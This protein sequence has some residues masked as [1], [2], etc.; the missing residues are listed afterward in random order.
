M[1]K[2]FDPSTGE[3]KV[4]ASNRGDGL[5]TKSIDF[6]S[7]AFDAS[8]YEDND[9]SIVTIDEALYQLKKEIRETKEGVAWVYKNGTVGG[10]GG[11]GSL[12]NIS[13]KVES[14]NYQISNK[15]IIV[16]N[17]DTIPLNFSIKG[18]AIGRKMIITIRDKEGN[19]YDGYRNTT[20]V[21]SSKSTTITIPNITKDTYIEF[22]GYDAETLGMI[23]PYTL[24]IRVAALKI[25]G[26]ESIQIP[27]SDTEYN[28]EY[29]IETTEGQMTTLSLSTNIEGIEYRYNHDG[30]FSYN[31][32]ISLN[33]FDIFSN[34][35]GKLNLYDA[36]QRGAVSN[37]SII[38][39]VVGG[40]F[41]AKSITSVVV[42][43]PNKITID[44][45]PLDN[46]S[47]LVMDND[48]EDHYIQIENLGADLVPSYQYIENNNITF[49]VK[50]YFNTQQY[51]MYYELYQFDS[52][53]TPITLF[54]KGNLDNYLDISNQP[55]GT[56]FYQ[57][58]TQVTIPYSS[59]DNIN[60]EKPI[61]I[62]VKAWDK[63]D[64][65]EFSGEVTKW[66]GIQNDA[67]WAPF[68]VAM[69][70]K[71]HYDN[72]MNYLYYY[73][74][75]Y[76]PMEIPGNSWLSERSYTGSSTSSQ[77]V[78]SYIEYYNCNN[79]TN[80]LVLRGSGLYDNNMLRLSSNAYAKILDNNKNDFIPF[81]SNS[82][83]NWMFDPNGWTMSFLVNTDVQPD[84]DNV[85]I[86]CANFD[87]NDN[88]TEGIYITTEDVNVIFQDTAGDN[89]KF[90]LTAKLAQGMLNQID[91]VFIPG[92]ASD[93]K[94]QLKLYVN[95]VLAAAGIS[96]AGYFE[97]NGIKS[98]TSIDMPITFGAKNSIMSGISKAADVNIYRVM[99]Y[100]R[101]LTDFHIVKNY[102]QGQAEVNLLLDG[103]IDK[104][105]NIELRNKNFF[106]ANDGKCALIDDRIENWA[107]ECKV[108]DNLYTKL[109]A[110]GNNPL[111]IVCITVEDTVG[112]QFRNNV[113]SRYSEDEVAADK[114][115]PENEK[116]I[117]KKYQA[118]F[119]IIP[120]KSTISTA[121]A[122]G[123][124]LNNSITKD[125]AQ[126][127]LPWITLQ[128]TSTLGYLS[129]NFQIGFGH[130]DTKG[131]HLVQAF[132]DMLPENEYILKADVM[133]SGHANNAAIGKF[134][135]EF[136][137]SDE[138]LIFPNTARNNNANLYRKEVKHTTLGH[139][140]IL[141][142][143]F[144]TTEEP[145]FMGIYSFNL[146]RISYYN[147]GYNVFDG[148]YKVISDSGEGATEYQVEYEN[149][150]VK[151]PDIKFPAYVSTYKAI[152]IP[153]TSDLEGIDPNYS[154]A[155]CYECNK[156]DNAVGSFQQYNVVESFYDKVYPDEN[157]TNT[158]KALDNFKKIF[159][160]TANMY[161]V[162]P[163]NDIASMTSESS[164]A[165]RTR[166]N[167]LRN[168]EGK[169]KIKGSNE[170][171]VFNLENYNAGLY[172][173]F[174]TKWNPTSQYLS[175]TSPQGSTVDEEFNVG[176][177]WDHASA[178]F[179]LAMLF[180][181]TDSLGKN[182]NIRSF[183]QKSWYTSFYDMDTGLAL[184]NSGNESVK[185][186]AYLD[187][188]GNNALGNN[189]TVNING[190]SSG[191][192][193][194]FNSRLWNIV[195]F[196]TNTYD[197][198]DGNKP[199]V[200]Y[201]KIWE[202][203]RKGMLLDPNNF[204]DNY[205]IAQNKNVGEIIFNQD[206][207]TKYVQDEIDKIDN[208]KASATS[209]I[210]LLHGNRV[211]FVKDWF[212]KHVY[213]LDGV[214][215]LGAKDTT[216]SQSSIQMYGNYAATSGT[217]GGD[218]SKAISV[219]Y[220]IDEAKAAPYTI[221]SDQ[222]DRV[223]PPS[224]GSR[225][226]KVKSNIPMFFIYA[227]ST[228]AQRMYIPEGK[229]TT[230]SLNLVGGNEQTM[231][232]N[233]VP[234]LTTF[235]K[236][237]NMFYV[238]M[239]DIK[240]RMLTKL[241]LSNM[242]TLSGKTFNIG[243]MEELRILNMENVTV[244]DQ[245]TYLT[246][247][248]SNAKKINY[249]NLRNA[250]VNNLVLPGAGINPGGSLETLII[251]KTNITSIDLTNQAMLST[252]SANGCQVLK[253]LK[254]N[255]NHLLKNI[256]NLPN[257]IETLTIEECKSLES[258]NLLN[259]KYLE[260]WNENTRKGFQ[261]GKVPNL[262]NFSY[263][264]SN[265]KGAKYL[266]KLD[267]SGATSLETLDIQGF[268]GEYITLAYSAKDTLKDINIANSKIRYI[269]WKDITTDKEYISY[270]G[271]TEDNSY[272]LFDYIDVFDFSDCK[273]LNSF[274]VGNTLVKYIILPTH[275]Y[276][277]VDNAILQC[278]NLERIIGKIEISNNTLLKQL[279]KF[280]FND[281]AR[282]YPDSPGTVGVDK[283]TNVILNYDDGSFSLAELTEN[284]FDV[285][286]VGNNKYLNVHNL[287]TNFEFNIATAEELCANSAINI[288]DMYSVLIKLGKND[289]I[290]ELVKTFE[291]CIHIKC[292][293]NNYISGASSSDKLNSYEIEKADLL[294]S[295]D[296]FVDNS[297]FSTIPHMFAKNSNIKSLIRTFAN[298]YIISDLDENLF[299]PLVNLENLTETF[300]GNGKYWVNDNMFM[301]NTN[302]KVLIN[303]FT[304]DTGS[305][306]FTLGRFFSK[307]SELEIINN[308]FYNTNVNINLSESSS[309]YRTLTTNTLGKIK[310]IQIFVNNPK[311]HTI[312]NWMNTAS[313][314]ITS[315]THIDLSD[316]FGGV[317]RW[318]Y[319]IGEITEDNLTFTYNG[320]SCNINDTYPR[321]LTNLSHALASSASSNESAVLNWKYMDKL[322]YNLK[323]DENYNSCLE[324]C[325][326][327]FKGIAYTDTNKIKTPYAMESNGEYSKFPIDIF[328]VK[329]KDGNQIY[330]NNLTNVS[331]MFE[332]AAFKD[333]LD[334]PGNIFK[335]CRNTKGLNISSFLKN[336]TIMP[337][338]LVSVVTNPEYDCFKNCRLTIVDSVLEGCGLG[339]SAKN[340]EES[341][342]NNNELF[343]RF[344]YGGVRNS[345]PYKFF[346]M[347]DNTGRVI[348]NI[349]SM[350]SAFAGCIWMGC[351]PNTSNYQY[352]T[353]R[354]KDPNAFYIT[355]RPSLDELNNIL[356]L[357]TIDAS[358]LGTLVDKDS[359]GVYEWDPWSYDGTLLSNE[360]TSKLTAD[361]LNKIT[362]NSGKTTSGKS[363]LEVKYE[364]LSDYEQHIID[365]NANVESTLNE[366]LANNNDLNNA[367][368]GKYEVVSEN[369]S[370]ILRIYYDADKDSKYVNWD[371]NSV[372]NEGN[373]Y[374][375]WGMGTDLVDLT[376]NHSDLLPTKFVRN[377]IVPMDIFRYCKPDCNIN[378]IFENMSRFNR[379]D[380][381]DANKRMF[382]YGM[383][384]RIPPRIFEPL[385]DLS[386]MTSVFRGCKGVVPYS[387]SLDGQFY[388]FMLKNNKNL[389]NISYTF[390][391]ITIL[392]NLSDDLI[393]YNSL[394]RNL[395]GMFENGYM[396]PRYVSSSDYVNFIPM[397]L[398]THSGTISNL[399]YMFAS[400]DNE[401]DESMMSFDIY[402]TM[403][404]PANNPAL[405]SVAGIFYNQRNM[406]KTSSNSKLFCNFHDFGNIDYMNAYFGTGYDLSDLDDDIKSKYGY[407]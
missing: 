337:I 78:K 283:L 228:N 258:I 400:R 44:V 326:Y 318:L 122:F 226:F 158:E 33:I 12:G 114:K 220:D 269:K 140:C 56:T 253:S 265:E 402:D 43:N 364:V 379:T 65:V 300:I 170:Y 175:F 193:D 164:N 388:R 342:R 405:V 203:L 280:K 177:V 385:K 377:Y 144:R 148:L 311:L 156:N 105:S 395:E 237:G 201:R 354:Y 319:N 190:Y 107:N 254:L 19:V 80:G 275:K 181:L 324:E 2:I 136:L 351:K 28:I 35:N 116:T 268:A 103:T 329:D 26:P 272:E 120:A 260:D 185:K 341:I 57:P 368:I 259:M 406:P 305:G 86:S 174:D 63:V 333:T 302:I 221:K 22:S 98:Y 75:S 49:T 138:Q 347:E 61:F 362:E 403:L 101:W 198:T 207:Y 163:E 20:Y 336:T 249:I 92:K 359:N 322:F 325:A 151:N 118:S 214:F 252:F 113:N 396:I 90:N 381:T 276:F 320:V 9:P 179:V 247:N 298:T 335:Y 382:I 10:G 355:S 230:I 340:A 41:E 372:A 130:S 34:E 251:D 72:Y 360:Y 227:N 266:T 74:N 171:E 404:I 301:Y 84:T 306:D 6:T 53:N 397:D 127:G 62:Y 66:F 401:T 166:S 216:K 383:I 135:N 145:T 229:E 387:Q 327:I 100:K 255:N 232:Y 111:P 315:G 52:N 169:F 332:G 143:K 37:F 286:T 126:D 390:S 4:V 50:L 112:D 365:S 235:D 334:F 184:T 202:S 197:E 110:D 293:L 45:I 376:Y 369:D 370:S 224:S 150:K 141:F 285:K 248:L 121:F 89:K 241:D 211:N 123:P 64:P 154:T 102:I 380:R 331:G 79:T 1:I 186:D 215:D 76:T 117:T 290:T 284:E 356:S 69:S 309:N 323:Y 393:K 270:A 236:L 196:L 195:R 192:Y 208:P 206:Y 313:K 199:S 234:Y 93:T 58:S 157:N 288:S 316:I 30:Y 292:G 256:G 82:D 240:L 42:T 366:I 394:L 312:S 99:F 29:S 399:N 38:A 189:Y 108:V 392:G 167:L 274:K 352:I 149:H 277:A 124:G 24:N 205:Y 278:A 94:A 328:N 91:L 294:G 358:L 231:S 367:Y 291:N 14:P 96:N 16:N 68:H 3:Y 85:I 31:T 330:F 339:L 242:K 262:K 134:I 47:A 83:K 40:G 146:G 131:N 407:V 152:P 188:F 361:I 115:K 77:N 223:N 129:K 384:G 70:G 81:K 132:E 308:L 147:L 271:W 8:I 87:A 161:G 104:A 194:T 246:V 213:F 180:G 128:G 204:I 371:E 303:P 297:R 97:N 261:I 346:Y 71:D 142:V 88:F 338:N 374:T 398:F 296:E 349:L 357:S 191:G 244:H 165:Q 289:K 139:P 106:F 307:L 273:K 168:V 162:D 314:A 51:R 54:K 159:V 173:E 281:V 46:I 137:G 48:D 119:E 345:I 176:M 36:I 60:P 304:K 133:D 375:I 282:L 343:S 287:I 39:K 153:Y 353:A 23:E 18:S 5:Y 67:T 263:V 25:T 178:Y 73:W 32:K 109:T 210:S 218:N 55:T 160:A 238:T 310:V 267:L 373:A 386:E 95:S 59:L 321:E 172:E 389:S 17:G 217:Y 245:N 350:K 348:N 233:F 183:D 299:K 279:P 243:S 187:V 15:Q 13:F 155:V 378:N 264:P 239:D 250:A 391:G 363:Y 222:K 209:S 21:V 317:S 212:T 257:T 7:A 200:N 11:G 125:F 225:T 182:L 219:L 295:K 27:Q 344:D